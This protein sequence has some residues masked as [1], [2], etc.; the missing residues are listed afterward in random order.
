[1]DL[2]LERRLISCPTLPSLPAVALEVLHL[3]REEDVDLR[4]VGEALSRDPALAARVLR[5][6]NSASIAAR[7]KVATLSRAVP[8]LGSNTTLA[9]ALSFSLVRSRRRDERDGFDH[10][11]FWRRAVFSAIAG[12]ALAELGAPGVDGEEVFLAALLQDVGMLAYAEVFGRAY[13]ELWQRAAGDHGQLAALERGAWGSDHAEASA[14]LARTW[15]LP[16]RLGDAARESHRAPAGDASGEGARDRLFLAC[17]A[18]SGPLAEVWLAGGRADAIGAALDAAS[19]A[20]GLGSEALEP[21]LSRMAL[22]VGE[23]AADFD[24]DL[25]GPARVEEVLA[26][27]RR[28][29]AALGIVPAPRAD[30]PRPRVESGPA[31]DGALRWALD[32]AHVRHESLALLV[33]AAEP[34]TEPAAAALLAVARGALRATDLVGLAE[35][36]ELTALLPATTAAGARAAAQRIIERGAALE[37]PLGVSV[38]I[39]LS[40]PEEPLASAEHLR[41]LAAAA[42]LT[43]GRGRAALA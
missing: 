32:F 11:A 16:R 6:A 13:G 38:G 26:E 19:A 41:A 30:P 42:A 40:L 12:R 33:V 5:A 43:A 36:G 22:L 20:L 35:N 27:A 9:L 1:M 24:I 25:G 34:A 37:P 4:R 23:A 29:P 21:L 15:N 28:L 2:E 31:L 17:V 18:Q 7:G 10:G 39:A 3:C 14:L 8:L